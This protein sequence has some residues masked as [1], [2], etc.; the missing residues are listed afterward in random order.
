MISLRPVP[1]KRERGHSCIISTCSRKSFGIIPGT[2]MALCLYHYKL[3]YLWP[4]MVMQVV[5]RFGS[6][7][8]TCGKMGAHLAPFGLKSLED[9]K[10]VM[11]KVIKTTKPDEV[12][13]AIE[14]TALTCYDCT[15]AAVPSVR[16]SPNWPFPSY[17][18]FGQL[19]LLWVPGA[20][21]SG[22]TVHVVKADGH[23]LT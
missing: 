21:W 14:W 19:G 6:Q 13:K 7:C 5:R 2:E 17:F 20:D 10:P 9:D 23:V 3:C 22:R 18:D 1:P 8:S 15:R 12:E 4:S 16:F 11:L